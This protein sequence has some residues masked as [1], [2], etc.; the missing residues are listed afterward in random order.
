MSFSYLGFYRVL[1]DGNSCPFFVAQWR[2]AASGQY[3][4]YKTFYSYE[5]H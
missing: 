5:Q 3:L 4:I 2:W 1:E